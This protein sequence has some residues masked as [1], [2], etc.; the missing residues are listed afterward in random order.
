MLWLFDSKEDLASDSGRQQELWV[1]QGQSDAERAAS[2][3]KHSVDHG[4]FCDV[5][6]S[7]RR[8]G[9]DLR[10]VT[11]LN[12]VITGDRQ[13]RFNPKLI[14]LCDCQ[15]RGLLIAIFAGIE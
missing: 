3:I 7:D 6:P 5:G 2:S 4:N 10:P 9:P 11:D 8:L 15:Y 13:E 1:G 14:D 12:L